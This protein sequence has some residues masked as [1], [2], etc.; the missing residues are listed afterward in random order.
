MELLTL[1]MDSSVDKIMT[2]LSSDNNQTII[3]DKKQSK[4]GTPVTGCSRNNGKYK[5]NIDD[6]RW[7]TRK[8]LMAVVT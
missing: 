8:P 6:I 4:T 3:S 5:N 2:L 1:S 7:L